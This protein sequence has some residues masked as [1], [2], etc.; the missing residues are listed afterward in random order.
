MNRNDEHRTLFYRVI[1][2]QARLAMAANRKE[3]ARDVN[4][5]EYS[6]AVRRFHVAK[7]AM[8]RA[9]EKLEAGR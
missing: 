4:P 5:I 6:T 2:A 3:L 1:R 7:R 8:R 9:V